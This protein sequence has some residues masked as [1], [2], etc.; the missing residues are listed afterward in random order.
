MAFPCGHEIERKEHQRVF[1]DSWNSPYESISYT[2]HHAHV[3]GLLA[4]HW[5]FFRAKELITYR[6]SGLFFLPN[7]LNLF[8]LAREGSQTK[9]KEAED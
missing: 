1:E 5:S 6:L 4:A 3:F 7:V 8:N 9:E 2:R